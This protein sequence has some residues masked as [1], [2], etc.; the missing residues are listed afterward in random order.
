MTKREKLIREKFNI[1]DD[2]DIPDYVLRH[3]SLKQLSISDKQMKWARKV[4]I[5]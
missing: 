4:V 2:E 1:P 5:K 3:V